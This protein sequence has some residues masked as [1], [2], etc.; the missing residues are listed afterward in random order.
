MILLIGRGYGVLLDLSASFG[1]INHDDLFCILEKYVQIC[2][3]TLKLI[4]GV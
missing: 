1:T 3:N 2:G 4:T